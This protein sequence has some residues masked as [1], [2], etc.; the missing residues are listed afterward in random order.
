VELGQQL[1][2][3]LELAGWIDANL[4]VELPINQRSYLA[5]ACYDVTIEHHAAILLLA[6]S[7]LYGSMFSLMRV[8]FESLA[9]GMWLRHCASD[10]ELK[11]FERG[12]VEIKFGPLVEQVEAAVGAQGGALSKLK[13]NSWGLMNSL[14]HTGIDQVKA[15]HASGATGGNYS[16]QAVSSGLNVAGS[17]A[18]LA[19]AELA[20]YS[21]RPELVR[22]VMQ[23][24]S[25][26]AAR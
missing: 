19:A 16:P 24:A 9:R 1:E 4:K 23:R 17:L 14:T 12:V 2:D 8:A 15:R 25:E 18:L 6:Q 22:S 26:Y 11:K 21:A 13:K 3:Q 7:E 20:S 5:I 10:G